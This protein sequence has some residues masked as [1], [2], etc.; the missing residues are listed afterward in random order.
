MKEARLLAAGLAAPAQ[1]GLRAGG[2]FAGCTLIAE[3]GRG[4]MGVVFTAQQHGS[5]RIVAIKFAHGSL[6]GSAEAMR[7]FRTEAEA[8]AALDHPGIL[9]I[10]EVGE[11]EGVA[12]YTMRFAEAGSLAER[13]GDFREPRA[14]ATL[15]AKLADAVQHAHARGILHRD[16]KPGN[17]L[18]ASRTEPLVSDFGLARW[19]QR[20]SDATASLSVLGTPDY[21]A[22]EMLHGAREGSTTA[23]DIFSL[24]AI[25]YHLLAGRAPFAG[26]SVAEIL[27][28][29]EQCAPPPLGTTPRDLAAVCL[30][31]LEREPARRYASAGALAADLRA[32]LDGRAVVARPVGVVGHLLRWARRK[33]MLAG[34]TTALLASLVALG[35]NIVVSRNRTLASEHRRAVIAERFAREQHRTALL[36]RAQLRLQ[37][38]DAGR[39]AEVLRLLREAWPLGPSVEIRS[40]AIR[41]LSTLDVEES[42]IPPS[43]NLPEPQAPPECDVAIPTK[44]VQRA[45]DPV[46]HRFAFSGQDKLLY[47]VD[48]DR[49]AI[50][51]R[52]RGHAGVTHALR[53]SPDGHWLASVSDDQTLRLW[54]VRGGRESLV[55]EHPLA[56]GPATLRWSEDGA[57]L[58][59]AQ[60]RALRIL[61]PTVAHTFIPEAD[62]TRTEELR[63]IDLSADGRWLVTVGESGTRLWSKRTRRQAA[64]FPKRD[65]EWSTARFSPDSRQLW[66]G[67]WNSDLRTVALPAN[68]D[69]P[70]AEP[71]PFAQ[72]AGAL[73]EQSDDG[74]WL[75]AVSNGRG[76]FQFLSATKSH[77][78]F[79]LK[80]PH[81]LSLALSR[82]GRHAA[83][84][85]YDSPG[86]R[87]WDFASAKVLRQLPAEPPAQLAFT[88]D[89]TML[90]TGSEQTLALWSIESGARAHTFTAGARIHSL[91]FSPDGKWL[92][93]ETRTGLT[94]HRATAPFDELAR[95]ATVPDRGTASFAFS[96]DGQR[97]AVQT[98]NGGAVLWQLNELARALD[99][100]GMAWEK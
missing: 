98:A 4:A 95:L 61:A 90:A 91:A 22:P 68:D 15:V 58:E 6:A 70:I 92:A 49:R 79:W 12:Y 25:L 89:G 99:E 43:A 24:G 2:T 51:R 39:R 83:T 71:A 73:M 48:P 57:W 93:L 30:K 35:V 32:W 31:C 64:L 52:L 11:H 77:R 13:L 18:L 28:N 94:L 10:H 36:A 9:P 80:H 38:H 40:A 17:I 53:F 67:G 21:L 56:F 42:V 37:S 62:D 74:A 27:Q 63:T 69:A 66:I 7:R 44:I 41:A 16:L 54:D 96:R 46:A 45:Y 86:V 100:L 26:A 87:I 88:P 50:V 47:L 14:A 82:D 1:L 78:S 59:V 81:P 29:V 5:Q 97:L 72:I 75:A 55:R 33:P 85:S 60:G 84:S 34:L 20:D 76:G 19:L 65:G 3:V 23:A 8:V